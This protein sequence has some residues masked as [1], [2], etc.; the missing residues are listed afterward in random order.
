[1][2]AHT[3]DHIPCAEVIRSVWDYLDDEIDA[4]RKERIRRH[5]ELCDHCRDQ[6]SFEGAFIRNVS[7]LLDADDDAESLRARVESALVE[8][9]FPKT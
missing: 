5:L 7:R 3:V 1:M 2:T 4:D 9:G 6:Y 8:H